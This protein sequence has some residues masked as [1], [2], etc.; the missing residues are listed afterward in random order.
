MTM[1][2]RIPL[3]V[4]AV[5]VAW[6]VLDIVIHGVIL[7][8]DYAETAHLW[9]PKDEMKM[10]LLY[11]T[12]FIASITFTLIYACL[13]GKKSVATGLKYGLLFG[14]GWGIGMG[15]GTY[16]V[17]PIPYKLALV[18]FLGVVVEATIGGLLLGLILP[19]GCEASGESTAPA[20][21]TSQ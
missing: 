5:F 12:G 3:A 18:W 9:R 7:S 4:L 8:G 21:S 14:I 10:G 15:Y 16:S 20:E 13:I 19:K 17:M 11:L 1:A 6:T 2:I